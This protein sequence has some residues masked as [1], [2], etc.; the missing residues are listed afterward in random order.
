MSFLLLLQEQDTTDDAEGG[1][2]SGVSDRGKEGPD[3]AHHLLHSSSIEDI[4]Q[5]PWQLRH[6]EFL[7][8]QQQQLQRT[9]SCKRR[10]HREDLKG[11][12]DPEG[13][14]SS[15]RV[16]A[17][18]AAEATAEESVAARL[19]LLYDMDRSLGTPNSMMPSN[20]KSLRLL[21]T[22]NAR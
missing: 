11:T 14:G 1:R 6:L 7:E 16:R 18:V 10:L 15:L 3:L 5:R 20:K 22:P 8:Q 13:S 17:A 21:Q 4:V 9:Q 12:P 2:V 19:Q